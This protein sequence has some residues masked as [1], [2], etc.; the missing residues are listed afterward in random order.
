MKDFFTL[1]NYIRT[2]IYGYAIGILIV[3]VTNLGE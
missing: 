3:F 2:L 1:R